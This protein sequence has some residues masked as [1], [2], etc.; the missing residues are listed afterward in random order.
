M[1]QITREASMA[2]KHEIETR[3]KKIRELT[4]KSHAATQN[5]ETEHTHLGRIVADANAEIHILLREIEEIA[6]T[7]G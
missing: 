4:A 1:G 5:R 2:A 3:T 6:S 7:M